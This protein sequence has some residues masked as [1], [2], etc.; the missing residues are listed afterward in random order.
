MIS[1][2]E[3]VISEF[4]QISTVCLA[5]S[6]C[7]DSTHDLTHS[8][9]KLQIYKKLSYETASLTYPS[10]NGIKAKYALFTSS[11]LWLMYDNSLANKVLCI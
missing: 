11:H 6:K 7:S 2:I 10:E 8:G 1:V 3:K 9:V 4:H 5:I